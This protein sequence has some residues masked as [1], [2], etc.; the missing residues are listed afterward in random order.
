MC[1]QL[2]QGPFSI[3]YHGEVTC[4]RHTVKVRCG[5]CT[6]PTEVLGPGWSDLGNRLMRCPRCA[7][8]AIDN[9]DL[10]RAAMPRIRADISALG[11][12]L[13]ARVRVELVSAEELALLLP[14]CGPTTFGVTRVAHWG[15]GRAEALDVAILQGLPAIWFGRTIVH[16]NMHAWLAQQGILPSSNVVEEGMCELAAFG[17]LARKSDP[18]AQTL[19]ELMRSSRDPVYG[20][21]LHQVQAAVAAHGLRPVID[22]LRQTGELPAATAAAEG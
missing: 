12:A 18:F 1:R 4:A 13:G 22:H 5:L 21:G 6:R 3:S 10:V 17:W 16:E 20:A 11:F 9:R 7:E 8:G 15:N 2:P 19:R 14:G